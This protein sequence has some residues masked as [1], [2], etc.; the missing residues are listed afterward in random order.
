MGINKNSKIVIYSRNTQESILNSSYLALVLLS[1]NFENVSLLDGGYM[2]WVFENELLISSRPSYSQK[3]GDIVLKQND[4]IIDAEF[5]KNHVSY[6][7]ILDARM[8]SQY[9]G[10]SKS[11]SIQNLGHIPSAKS[12]YYN[13]KFLADNT[14]RTKD[15]LKQ[16]YLD[17]HELK[18]SDKIIVYSDN[19]FSASMEWFVLYQALG[20]KNTK[21][22]EASLPEWSNQLNYSLKKFKWE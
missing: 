19:I 13:D 6:T 2:A 4:I 16:I 20:F 12:S 15:E 21:I 8:P 1:H 18:K 10:T 22:Y 7:P 11:K 9:Y 5:L 17:G 3:D 14:L